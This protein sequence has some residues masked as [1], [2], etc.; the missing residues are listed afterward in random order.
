MSQH[1]EISRLLVD[2]ALG[3]LPPEAQDDVKAH[4]AG[5]RECS[6]ELRR[7]KAL[8][9]GTERIRGL[10]A[11]P[12]ACESAGQAIREAVKNAETKQQTSGRGISLG[13]IRRTTMNNRTAKLAAAAAVIIVVLGGV[14]FWPGGNSQN[15]RWWLGS[16]AV[17]G[18]EILAEMEKIET[19]VHREQAVFVG[20]YGRTHVSGN[21]SRIYKAADRSRQDRYYEHT[22]ESTFGDN[23]PDS[24]LVQ[25]TWKVP[26]GKD[27]I[28]Y[29]VSHEHRRYT[30]T[31]AKGGAYKRDPL[32]RLRWYVGLLNKADRVLDT[33]TFDGREC[34]GFEIDTSKYGSNPPGRTDR[35][36]FD[37][38]TRLPVRIE[39]HGLPVTDS[40]G[41]TFTFIDD[42]F[43]YHAMIPA[44]KFVPKIPEGF[45]DSE[46]AEARAAKKEQTKDDMVYAEVP[47]GL[48]GE[49][50][51]AL[52]RVKTAS[53]RERFGFIHDGRWTFSD[54]SKLYISPNAWREDSYSGEQVSQMKFF[55]ARKE[56]GGKASFDFNDKEFKLTQTTVNLGDR[57]Y[58]IVDHG[59]K[60]HPDNPMDRIVTI[61]ARLSKADRFWEKEKIDG[62]ECFGFE[63][64]ARK[65]GSN[66]D[67]H[68]HMMWFDAE[69]KLPVRTE[70][71]WLQAE[72]PRRQI[73]DDFQWNPE[74]PTD[75]FEPEIPDD[76]TVK[77]QN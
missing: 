70:F 52:G 41:Q 43:E 71:R 16:A 51:A 11:D 76:F 7:L 63:L 24:V 54:G 60:S 47:Q 46:T 59:S 5:C 26:D 55:V 28:T 36:W 14:T 58:R 39:R 67:T 29:S 1:E 34:V 56:D 10:S 13:F 50:A 33:K 18:Q 73:R 42:Q 69:T 9:D 49:V 75:T 25:V 12:L 22:D 19:L 4:L 68:I 65:Y 57:N 77:E 3:D 17:W 40:P 44:E 15:G 72:G 27:L 21:W 53:Y 8:L 48:R 23:S 30:I 66:P 74:L 2:F 32:E 45:V 20:R 62:V 64:T 31:T 61:A 38:E 37:V 6:G 35:I